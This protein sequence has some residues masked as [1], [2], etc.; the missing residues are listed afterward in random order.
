ME[1]A[2]KAYDTHQKLEA[3]ERAASLCKR[4]SPSL[5]ARGQLTRGQASNLLDTLGQVV[6]DYHQQILL[7]APEKEKLNPSGCSG[8]NNSPGSNNLTR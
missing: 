3:V 8:L 5:I 2:M 1:N 6:L 7:Q 4:L